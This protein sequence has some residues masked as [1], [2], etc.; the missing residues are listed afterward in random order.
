MNQ[1]RRALIVAPYFAPNTNIG[2]R[3]FETVAGR[4]LK[5][6]WHVTV[7]A[8]RDDSTGMDMHSRGNPMWDELVSLGDVSS[9]TLLNRVFFGP[10]R[11]S[12]KTR[13]QFAKRPGAFYSVVSP[14]MDQAIAAYLH[15]LKAAGIGDP[16]SLWSR[17]VRSWM[18][19]LKDEKVFDFIFAS[20]PPV[21]PVLVAC[22][23][24]ERANAK[25]IIDYR[26]PWIDPVFEGRLGEISPQI[27]ADLQAQE[28][29]CL[30]RADLVSAVSP[31]I[32]SSLH[33]KA[34]ER[35][36]LS[37]HGVPD[38]PI[39]E[40]MD[41]DPNAKAYSFPY[42]FYAGNLYYGRSLSSVLRALKILG[43]EGGPH[44]KLVYCGPNV[45]L[46]EKSAKSAGVSKYLVA[47]NSI[48]H[49][50][51]LTISK[52]ALGNL[53]L[54]ASGYEY[55]Y[56]GKLW[57]QIA[58]GRPIICLSSSSGVSAQLIRE[59][60]LGVVHAAA[61][62]QGIAKSIS[63]LI[64]GGITIDSDVCRDLSRARIIDS[65]LDKVDSLFN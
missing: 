21:S 62:V 65:L 59:R 61:D 36:L 12:L 41:N 50:Q 24:A 5:R 53:L 16:F 58:V 47:T 49:G 28:Q 3:R 2:G 27:L 7:V 56:P 6:G 37:P 14:G 55:S 42:L 13:D 39:F 44:V 22:E 48:S 9:A 1:K 23:I 45:E 10:L 30:N 63:K 19:R 29:E 32:V 26:D 57:D 17:Q 20:V 35:I 18:S 15:L 43:S 38:I 52:R 31:A 51:V 60:Q 64:K 11:L 4:M 34:S 33:S 54:V 40:D 46:A 25:I 8:P